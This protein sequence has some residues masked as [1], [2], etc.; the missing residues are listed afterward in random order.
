MITLEKAKQAIIASENKAKELGIAVSTAIVD[1]YGVLIA[2]SKMDGALKVSPRF[3]QAKAH[4]AAA[5]GLPSSDVAQYVGEG[6]PY[7]A[8]HTFFT[9][10]WM[11]IAGGLPIKENGTT[12]GAIGVG[13]SMD[14][15][16]DAQ[17]AQAAIDALQNQTPTLQAE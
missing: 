9:G 10:E 11:V 15:S 12:V 6:K 3:S 13:G 14:V 2:F 1:E 16:E 7:M 8:A 17:C 4:T 5:L